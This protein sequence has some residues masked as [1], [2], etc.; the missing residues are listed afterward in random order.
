MLVDAVVRVLVLR[1]ASP[2]W[3]DDVDVGADFVVGFSLGL[4]MV[5]VD[6]VA[7]EEMVVCL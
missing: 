2:P 6:D 7:G 5:A 4:R 3:P 1:Y